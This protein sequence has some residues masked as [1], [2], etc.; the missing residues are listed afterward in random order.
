MSKAKTAAEPQIQFE[1]A[2]DKLELIVRS[3]EK[4]ELTLEMSLQSYEEG[5]RLLQAC[6][7]QLQSA[8]QRI[9]LLAKDEN[10]NLSMKPFEHMATFES[11]VGVVQRSN[12]SSN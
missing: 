8:E 5:I 7:S 10:L 6:F 9:H 2:V 4:G 1:A 11:S 12:R 3:L